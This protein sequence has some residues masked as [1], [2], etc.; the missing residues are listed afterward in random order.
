MERMNR[1]SVGIVIAVLLGLAGTLVLVGYVR[2][3]ENR[4]VAGEKLVHVLVASKSVAAGTAAEDLRSA[5]TSER[6]PAK[7]RPDGAVTSLKSLT[8]LVTATNLVSGEQLLRPRFVSPGQ[9]TKGVGEVKLP[10]GFVE[11]TLSLEPERAVGGLI[12]PGDRVVVFGSVDTGTTSPTND[13]TAVAA[14]SLVAHQVLVTNIQFQDRANEPSRDQTKTVAPTVNLLV[15]LGLDDATAQKVLFFAERGK[16]WLGAE[17]KDVV[18]T[19]TST[20]P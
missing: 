2:G 9:V 20:A 6:V 7:V 5:T 4:A 12:R 16:V 18:G 19:T 1:R 14:T 10:S 15:T 13:G 8:G 17:Q 3:A 11:V